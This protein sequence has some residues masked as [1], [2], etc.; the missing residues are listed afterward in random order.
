MAGMA[1][2]Q[3]VLR[4]LGFVVGRTTRRFDVGQ[5][6]DWLAM[7]TTVHAY[8]H[9][10]DLWKLA[11]LAGFRPAEQSRL[12]AWDDLA[13]RLFDRVYEKGGVFHLWGHSWEIDRCHG[14]AKLDRV[15]R[16]L[17]V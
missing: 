1:A 9:R 14:W 7:P 11:R 12:W 13:I 2:H 8:S 6:R 5:S 3:A 15:L 17:S 16:P 10:S 4:E